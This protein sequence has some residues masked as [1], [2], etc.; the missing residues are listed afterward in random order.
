MTVH[1]PLT[2]KKEERICSKLLI[3]KLFNGEESHS[4]ASYPLRMVFLEYERSDDTPQVQLLISVPKRHLK[5]AVDRN[6]I[7][8]LVREAYRKNKHLITDA[9][10]NHPNTA[11]AMAIIW[12]DAHVSDAR[13]VEKKVCNILLRMSEQLGKRGHGEDKYIIED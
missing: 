2:F 5:H 6:R 12:L 8:R 7:K 13:M 10:A 1:S 4:L 9:L 11:I 3:E